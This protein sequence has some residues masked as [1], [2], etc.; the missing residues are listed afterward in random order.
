MQPEVLVQ[1]NISML[2]S[3][4]LDLVD[5]R[6]KIF[7]EILALSGYFLGVQRALVSLSM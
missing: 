7:L 1:A 2:R 4:V 3:D 5:D 6:L